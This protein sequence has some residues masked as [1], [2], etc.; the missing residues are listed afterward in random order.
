MDAAEVVAELAALL[1]RALVAL[2]FGVLDDPDGVLVLAVA[3]DVLERVAKRGAEPPER[4]RAGTAA[5]RS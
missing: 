4:S 1:D 2:L 5:P 3:S